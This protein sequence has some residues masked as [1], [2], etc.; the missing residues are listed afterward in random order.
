MLGAAGDE[1]ALLIGRE[2]EQTLLTSV[3]DEVAARGQAR[4]GFGA[5]GLV[6]QP[7]TRSSLSFLEGR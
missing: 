3:L 7:G 4:A 6:A 1:V 2:Q 5:I